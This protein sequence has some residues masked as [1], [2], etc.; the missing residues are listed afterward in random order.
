MAKSI[1]IIK[2]DDHIYQGENEITEIELLGLI[3][4]PNNIVDFLWI[5]KSSEDELLIRNSFLLDEDDVNKQL[6]MSYFNMLSTRYPNLLFDDNK[7]KKIKE[8][9]NASNSFYS[10]FI[11]IEFGNEHVTIFAIKKDL[12]QNTFY[13]KL[14]LSLNNYI[15]IS[16]FKSNICA[17]NLIDM[18]N[19][20]S[21]YKLH[22]NCEL[23]YLGAEKI[24]NNIL[25]NGINIYYSLKYENKI[26]DTVKKIGLQSFFIPE[27]NIIISKLY[28]KSQLDLFYENN[29]V[30]TPMITFPFYWKKS[31]KNKMELLI[32]IINKKYKEI[33]IITQ[34][35]YLSIMNPFKL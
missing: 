7:T 33:Y 16:V 35:E 14:K 26:N 32:G 17:K 8:A 30:I 20:Y 4:T 11:P 21:N 12:K 22:D 31:I 6:D 15:R 2:D 34:D 5:F 10:D 29:I 24:N 9:F 25:N 3:K 18:M 28:S 13:K 19:D 23:S 27:T 1:N